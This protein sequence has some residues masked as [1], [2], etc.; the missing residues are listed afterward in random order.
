MSELNASVIKRFLN[1]NGEHP[2]TAADDAYVT[3]HYA[4]LGEV[5]DGRPETPDELRGHMLAGRLPMASYVRSDGAEMV[6]RD[7]LELPDKHGLDA[8]PEVFGAEYASY[9]KGQYVCLKSVTPANMRRKS[10]LVDHIEALVADARP[11][12]ADWCADL[13]SSADELD[14]L[15]PPFTA[16]DRLRFG[17]PVSRD[18]CIDA[19]RRD[20]PGA[21]LSG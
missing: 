6:H 18:R 5:T 19:V 7:Y 8:L 12:D 17:G 15:E 4:T 3:E 20:F 21:T 1:I 2:M 14:A 10:H 16:Y 13:R 11:G 9:I